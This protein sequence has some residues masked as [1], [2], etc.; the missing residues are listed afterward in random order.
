MLLH[1]THYEIG[2]EGREDPLYPYSFC[3]QADCLDAL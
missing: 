3:K 2:Y 1:I